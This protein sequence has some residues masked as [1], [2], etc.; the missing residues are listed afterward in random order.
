LNRQTHPL[1]GYLYIATATLLWGIGANLGRAAFTGRLAR[2]GS[3]GAITPLIL[4]QTRTTFSFLIIF[5]LLLLFRGWSRLRIPPWDLVRVFALGVLGVAAS[6]YFYYL[7]IQRTNV[8]VA[9]IVQYTAPVWVLTYMVLRGLQRVSLPR[10]VSVLL[11]VTGITIAVGVGS[12]KLQLDMLGVGAALLAAFSFA[13]YNIAGHDLLGRYDQWLVLLYTTLGAGLFWLVLNPPWK[14]VAAHY[15]A[16]QWWFLLIFALVS[17]LG[18]FSF[19]FAGLRHLEPTHAIIVSCLEPVFSIVIAAVV[20][21]ETLKKL[22]V[23]GI[24]LVLC[25]IAIIQLSYRRKSAAA[26]ALLPVDASK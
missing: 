2:F 12:G 9:I 1:R 21:G 18:P 8:A 26:Q 4:S 11:A 6:N 14:V 3:F 23:L 10:V 24:L 7:A 22:Q 15:S 16:V 17:V 19:Y 13:F 5:P 25:A 20:L